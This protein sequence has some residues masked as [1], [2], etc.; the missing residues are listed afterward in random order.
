MKEN[1]NI[2]SWGQGIER[3]LSSCQSAQMPVPEW[4][5]EHGGVWLV[6]HFSLSSTPPK[7]KEKT[8]GKTSG[9]TSDRIVEILRENPEVA[10][11]DL[12]EAL[13][14]STRAIELQIRKLQEKNIIQRIGPARGGRWEV[15]K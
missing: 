8:S 11:P 12:A 10:I 3:V 9:K 5:E 7:P 1:Q 14:R 2:E 4:R 15:L 6:F 13:G